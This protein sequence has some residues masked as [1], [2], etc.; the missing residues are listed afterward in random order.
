MNIGLSGNLNLFSTFLPLKISHSSTDYSSEKCPN[1]F[2]RDRSFAIEIFVSILLKR[3]NNLSS[4]FT[5]VNRSISAQHLCNNCNP[6]VAEIWCD[7]CNIKYCSTCSD[8]VHKQK[9][10]ESHYTIPIDEIT[11]DISLCEKHP[12]IK[13][14]YWCLDCETIICRECRKSEHKDH[15][16]ASISKISEEMENEVSI[17][18]I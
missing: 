9:T 5:F 17:K 14:E 18:Y 3:T 1:K 12:T 16:C 8:R 15:K 10:F 11:S 2:F 4:N 6:V 13:Y 7:E